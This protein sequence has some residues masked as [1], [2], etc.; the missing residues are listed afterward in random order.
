MVLEWEGRVG[1]AERGL[2]QAALALEEV[3]R[4]D[5]ARARQA[6]SPDRQ[7]HCFYYNIPMTQLTTQTL[8]VTLCFDP[9]PSRSWPWSP[10][11]LG[12]HSASKP[13]ADSVGVGT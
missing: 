9:Q 4:P 3:G 12:S 13:A 2:A 8:D 10:W 6:A 1:V 7:V 11:E 5:R